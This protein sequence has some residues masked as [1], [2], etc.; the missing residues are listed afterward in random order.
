MTLGSQ[1][2]WDDTVLPF[3]LDR[4]DIRGRVARL[5]GV[6]DQVL[7]QHDYPPVI[8]ALIAEAVSANGTHRSDNQASLEAV[9]SGARRRTCAVHCDGLLWTQRNAVAP[10]EIRAYASFDRERLDENAR[11]FDQIG[12]GYFRDLDRPGQGHDAISGHHADLWRLA[13]RLRRDV[14]CAVR[15]TADA[16]C[17]DIR[18]VAAARAIGELARRWR[19]A[20][21]HAQGV[22]VVCKDGSSGED[23]LLSAVD[24]LNGKE[25]EGWRRANVLLDTVEDIE[26]I[27]PTVHPTD[28]LVR[29][30]HEE[31]PRVF[32]PQALR[33]GCTCSSDRVRST[34]SIYSARDIAHMTTEGGVVTAD[35]QFCGAHY[36]LD[37]A[38]LGFEAEVPG[39]G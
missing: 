19:D 35:C 27:G 18:S 12:K 22:A 2:A 37:P 36:E 1:I 34:L 14:F 9:T 24:I 31:V 32:D 26:L 4:T 7:A 10:A 17:A 33:F 29:L 11:P 25:A 3:Q 38:T 39:D 21:T 28:L 5:D 23:G 15:A 30:F 8:E 13:C 20:S 6:L 16:L